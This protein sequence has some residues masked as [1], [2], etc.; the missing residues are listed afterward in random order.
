MSEYIFVIIW[1]GF[2][3]F[4]SSRLVVKKKQNVLGV[5]VERYFWFYAFLAFIPIIWMV[6]NRPDFGDTMAYRHAFRDMPNEIS[7]LGEYV[8]SKSKDKGFYLFS[9]IFRI[10]VSKDH[11]VYFL[12]IA[13][14]Q[15]VILVSIYRKYSDNY[16]LSAFLF[17]ASADYFSWMYNGIRQFTAATIIFAATALM[18]KKKYVPLILIIIFASLFHQSALV[19]LPIVFFVQGEAWNKKNM[20]LILCIIIV[21]AFLGSFTNFLDDTLQTTQYGN[22]VSDY[23]SIEDDGT[24]PI[25]VLVYSIPAIIAFIW[26]KK[27][28]ESGNKLINLCTN[29]SI[30]ASG[31]Y[32]VSMVT[33]GIFLGRL[34]IYCSLF[35]YILL[36]WE[37]SNLF[38]EDTKRTVMILTVMGYLAYYYY[39]IHFV[40]ALV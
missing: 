38:R 16:F 10:L 26:R 9:A 35:S 39:Q 17:I 2:L 1:I 18:I 22:V 27:I 25:R 29:M 31:L 32:V 21:L 7:Q 34:P 30:V 3:A 33:S 36:P 5:E 24:N 28:K 37:I 19:M 40:W 4:V 12:F 11:V 8:A 23:Q 14:I 20:I 13:L 6:G 15:S